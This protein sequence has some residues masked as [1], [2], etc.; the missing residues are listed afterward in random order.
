MY[1]NE[2]DIEYLTRRYLMHAILIFG[3]K[4]RAYRYRASLIS[5]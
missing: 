2:A 4:N 5:R 1:G 3:T